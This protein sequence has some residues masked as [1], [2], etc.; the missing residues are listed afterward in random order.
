[1]KRANDWDV[2]H[3]KPG[4]SSAI[5]IVIRDVSVPS[6]LSLSSLIPSRNIFTMQQECRT[7][8]I[9]LAMA[10]VSQLCPYLHTFRFL[11]N[12]TFLT[13]CLKFTMSAPKPSISGSGANLGF[14]HCLTV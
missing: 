5:S 1:V 4:S 12:D 2:S 14:G 9:S 11:I 3:L 13:L 7:T 6:R 10:E 8:N